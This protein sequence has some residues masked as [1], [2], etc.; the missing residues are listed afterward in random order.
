MFF[1]LAVDCVLLVLEV[2]VV[3]PSHALAMFPKTSSF[4]LIYVF[5]Y[6]LAML[7]SIF[8]LSSVLAIIGPSVYSESVLFII[9]IFTFIPS[10][11][12]P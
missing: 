5:V 11:V 1:L 12:R 10:T 8:P 3:E 9:E 4:N 7:L 6:A 2:L